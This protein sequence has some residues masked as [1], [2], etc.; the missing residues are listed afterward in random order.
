MNELLRKYEVLSAAKIGFE[1]EFYSELPQK[2]VARSMSIFLSKKVIIPKV[3]KGFGK[4]EKGNY[5]SEIEPTSTM[6]KLERDFSGG[7]DMYEMITGPIPYEE[8]R[9]MLIKTLQWIKE[10]GWTD[11]KCAIHLNISFDELKV[12]LRN[13]VMS[14]DV[15][16]FIL[17][18]DEEV[19]YTRFPNRRDSVYAK[20]IFNIYPVNRFVFFDRP[21]VIDKNMYVVP[22]EKYYGV[23]FTKLEKDYLEF[24]YLG[25]EGYENRTQ[26]IMELMDY[27]IVRIY[28]TLQSEDY[29]QEEKEKLY[30][31]L[32]SQK[33]VV[34]T[35]S[36]PERFFVAYPNIRITVDM[37]GD[38]EIVKAYW[39]TIREK[40][41]SLIADSGLRKGHFN[42]D[43]DV[44]AFQLM[45][46]EMMKANHIHQMELFDCKIS[47][48]LEEC[49]LYRCFVNSS[50]MDKCKIAETTTVHNSK[51][52]HTSLMPGNELINCYINNPKE[53]I[54][55]KVTGGVMR[56]GIVGR[57][58]EISPETLIVDS[59]MKDD[60]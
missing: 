50:R 25:G 24:R 17:G 7:K 10:F 31:I 46:G 59:K 3:V 22:D 33:K 41:F 51:V 39:T 4:E 11:P 43:T 2:E 53:L 23:N 30:S 52:E 20:S 55:G 47:G 29:N 44:S 28:N 5:H 9:I 45:D 6:F 35:F 16:K 21:E 27:F 26:R 57:H 60:K 34:E 18:F 40:L 37:K 13:S 58:A 42:L 12:K 54:D 38:I 1:F 15:L 36:H 49:T 8:A 32:R 56:K 14:M 48:T 19:V